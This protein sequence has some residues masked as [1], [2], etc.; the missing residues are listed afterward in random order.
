MS[1][2]K[3]NAAEI[4]STPT[5]SAESNFPHAISR[6]YF[7]AENNC[8]VASWSTT[9][10]RKL[11]IFD[12]GLVTFVAHLLRSLTALTRIS[13]LYSFKFLY[14]AIDFGYTSIGAGLRSLYFFP[15]L[16]ILLHITL[17]CTTSRVLLARLCGILPAL[18]LA[19]HHLLHPQRS[20]THTRRFYATNVTRSNT[21]RL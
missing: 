19:D 1:R 2:A 17:S 5:V 8:A 3:R 4:I 20:P 11:L 10:M 6:R 13:F 12:L 18:S 21:Q 15:A 14:V 7:V 9:N 16:V